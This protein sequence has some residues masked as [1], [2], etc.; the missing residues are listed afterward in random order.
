MKPW[1]VF[2]KRPDA[3]CSLARPAEPSAAKARTG[4]TEEAIAASATAGKQLKM[5]RRIGDVCWRRDLAAST[6]GPRDYNW[7]ALRWP[8]GCAPARRLLAA[9]CTAQVPF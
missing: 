9:D 1:S 6:R 8:R 5:K 3:G 4:M 7:R 2:T